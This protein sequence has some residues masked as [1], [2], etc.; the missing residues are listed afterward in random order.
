LERYP[1]GLFA[2]KTVFLAKSGVS[3][4]WRLRYRFCCTFKNR[5]LGGSF[6]CGFEAIDEKSLKGA[7]D[8]AKGM[9]Q[10]SAVIYPHFGHAKE[11][12]TF[13]N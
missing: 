9:C 1:T 12:A 3:D 4:I 8:Q 7:N 5:S 2:A 13:E 10:R 11:G 6:V